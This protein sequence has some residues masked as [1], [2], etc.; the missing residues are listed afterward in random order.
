MFKFNHCDI[1]LWLLVQVTPD[2]FWTRSVCAAIVFKIVSVIIN[3]TQQ[4]INNVIYLAACVQYVVL[5]HT[6]E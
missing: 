6:G 1:E 5:L 4:E 2:S 3:W